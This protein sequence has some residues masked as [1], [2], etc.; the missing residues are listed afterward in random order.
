MTVTDRQIRELRSEAIEAGDLLQAACCEIA[1]GTFEDGPTPEPGTPYAEA[2]QRWRT[3]A[4]AR[5]ECAR[6]IWDA[7]ANTKLGS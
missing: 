1:L 7:T 2:R 5:R 3:A 6:V 4:S